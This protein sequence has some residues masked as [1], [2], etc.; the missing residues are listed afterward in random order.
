[1]DKYS[2]TYEEYQPYAIETLQMALPFAENREEV[3]TAISRGLE[4]LYR[5]D[6]SEPS[7]RLYSYGILASSG[8]EVTTR[9]RYEI[10]RLFTTGKR[11]L[12]EVELL[13]LHPDFKEIRQDDAFHNWVKKQPQWVQDALYVNDDDAKLAARAIDLYKEDKGIKN[14]NLIDANKTLEASNTIE[15]LGV[16]Q[17]MFDTFTVAYWA[18]SKINDDARMSQINTIFRIQSALARPKK[19]SESDKG[20]GCPSE[21][22]SKFKCKSL[23][24]L[25]LDTY[26]NLVEEY[27]T[28]KSFKF[29]KKLEKVL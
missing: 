1:M 8:Y 28:P 24:A 26:L 5:M 16:E 12:A 11:E 20:G 17:E 29:G 14:D 4:A 23:Y 9:I 15:N 22:V 2:S 27:A 7:I 18:A 10:D 3:V 21:N 25:N 13:F 19:L 6:I